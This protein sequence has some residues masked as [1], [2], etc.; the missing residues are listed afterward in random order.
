MKNTL[1]LLCLL[2]GLSRAQTPIY[3]VEFI[4]AT[5]GLTDLNDYGCMIGTAPLAPASERGWVASRTQSITPLPLPPGRI[6]SRVYDINNAGQIVGSVSSAS[7]ADPGFGGVAALWTPSGAGGYVVQEL[8][9]LPGDIGSVAKALNE[10]GDIVGFSQGAY[11]RAV[12]LSAPGGVLD[13]TFTGA[14]DPVAIN[15]QRQVVCYSTRC[16]RLNLNTFAL[17]DLGLPPGSFASTLGRSINEAGQIAGVAISTSSTCYRFAARYSDGVGWQLLS[18]CGANNGAGSI[19]E[20]G[21]VT[22][23]NVASALVQLE[24]SGVWATQSLIS[25]PVGSWFLG[26]LAVGQ[27]NDSRQIATFASNPTT[28]QAGI[29]LLVPRGEVG[30]PLCAGDGSAGPC[31]CANA[32][33]PGGGEGCAHSGGHGA[34]LAAQG[35]NLVTDDNLVLSLSDAPALK[36]T[37]FVQGP[38]VSTT[39]FGAGLRCVGAPSV[40]LETTA[41]DANGS[42]STT[43][44]IVTRGAVTMGVTRGYQ[45]WFRDPLGPCAASNWSSALRV[46]WQ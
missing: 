46:D 32:S 31:P 45:A 26:A 29:V 11:Q 25:A 30:A 43:V 18:T 38:L 9:K 36:S 21:D 41:T 12:W 35:S 16:A 39:P 17:E 14:F 33:A 8:G 44:S 15:N 37:V 20:R 22:F 28:G 24:G 13:L 2:G 27:I 42:C 34:R 3:D 23:W 7:Y 40:R 10:L 4:G 1:L 19:N 5:T 6:S